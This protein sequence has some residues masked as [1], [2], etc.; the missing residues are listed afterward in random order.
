HQVDRASTTQSADRPSPARQTIANPANSTATAGRQ[1]PIAEFG[2]PPSPNNQ[3][4]AAY[5]ARFAF[6]AVNQWPMTS[7]HS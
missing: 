1:I 4:A 5:N 6:S 2:I 3:A 7:N